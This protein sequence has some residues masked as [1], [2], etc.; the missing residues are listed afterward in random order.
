MFEI[1]TIKQVPKGFQP[2]YKDE[3]VPYLSQ[4]TGGSY[5][6][7]GYVSKETEQCIELIT[8]EMI[9]TGVDNVSKGVMYWWDEP[10]FGNK[11]TGIANNHLNKLTAQYIITILLKMYIGYSYN[12]KISNEIIRETEIELPILSPE[13]TEPYWDYM[14]YFIHNIQ[15]QYA[16]QLE[17]KSEYE[18]DLMCQILGVTREE[19]IQRVEFTQP[20]Y[21]NTFRVGD[22]FGVKSIKQVP[23]G[24]K[25]NFVG[26]G[27]PY[28]SQKTGGS[29][30][31]NGYLNPEDV[32]G[33]LEL[34][35][36][37][38]IVTGVDNVAN[39]VMYWWDEPFYANKMV[40][41][42]HKDLDKW[43]AQYI[44]TLLLKQYSG[45]DY[46]NKISISI[47]K[48]TELELPVLAPNSKQIDWDAIRSVIIW[49]GPPIWLLVKRYA[50]DI[51]R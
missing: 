36:E 6:V 51:L 40:G 47:I 43:T 11:L 26:D 27:I 13:D 35:T 3:G 22:L 41:I 28:L 10:F 9:V 17:A 31:I 49:G 45:Y 23:S 37:G 1:R 2:D 39:G 18:L 32:D 19:I 21:T 46:N 20:Q 38:M 5:G 14:A 29:Y 50:T 30:G 25:P 33:E 48:D 34:I 44:I 7:N 4:K 8:N 42:T 24:F 16:D 15:Q 12:D